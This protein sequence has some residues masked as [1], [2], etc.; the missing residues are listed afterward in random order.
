MAKQYD[1]TSHQCLGPFNIVTFKGCFE[2]ELFRRVVNQDFEGL[3]FRK[4][5]NYDDHLSFQNIENLMKIPEK[6][7]N[8]WENVFRL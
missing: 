4:Y 1:K 5:I 6:Q 3:W 2:A 8:N 7:K